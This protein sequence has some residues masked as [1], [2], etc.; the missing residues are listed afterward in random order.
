MFWT[1]F[2]GPQLE[3]E[4]YLWFTCY[5]L[6][7]LI[8]ITTQDLLYTPTLSFSNE[9][10]SS[11]CFSY[12]TCVFYLVI[13][14]NVATLIS[15]TQTLCDL[16]FH[17][18]L[19]QYSRTRKPFRKKRKRWKQSCHASPSSSSQ[20][21]FFFHDERPNPHYY[22]YLHQTHFGDIFQH[23]C[24]IN[25]DLLQ[26]FGVQSAFFSPPTVPWDAVIPLA[27]TSSTSSEPTSYDL[28]SLVSNGNPFRFQS[29]FFSAAGT[30]PLIFDTGASISVSPHCDDFVTYDND[31]NNTTL[32]GVSAST[33]VAGKGIMQLSIPDDT[34]ALRTF[35][36]PALH[37]P[38]ATVRLLS[39]QSFCS[40]YRDK[41]SM[42]INADG[43]TFQF[44]TSLGGNSLIFNLKETGNL[45][46]VLATRHHSDIHSSYSSL[47]VHVSSSPAYTVLDSSNKNLTTAQKLVL[48]LHW[49]LMHINMGW[50]HW[51][52]REGIFPTHIQGATSAFCKCQACQLG[53][54]V[55]RAKGTIKHVLDSKKVGSL[56]RNS[57]TP[58][59][60]VSTDQFVSSVRGRLP[61]TFGKEHSNEKYQGGT[62]FV[63]EA[64]DYVFVQNQVSLNAEETLQGKSR[65]EREALHHGIL[66]K[67]YRGDNGVYRSQK[68]Q[69]D[70][71]DKNQPMRYSG[72]GAHHHNGIAERA[73]R[74]VSTNARTI[75]LHAMIHWPQE[76]QLDLWPFA[77]SYSVYLWNILPRSPSKLSPTEIFYGV[78]SDHSDLKNAKV[79]GCP[80][81]VLD[82]RLQDGKK[83]PKWDPRSQVGQFLGRSTQHASSVGLIRNV[84]TGKVSAQF[85]VVYDN[86]FTTLDVSSVPSSD[87]LPNEW[88]QLFQYQREC[89]FDPKDPTSPPEPPLTIPNQTLPQPALKAPTQQGDSQSPFI[90]TSSTPTQSPTDVPTSKTPLSVPEGAD[91]NI[92]PSQEPIQPSDNSDP[93]EGLRRSSRVKF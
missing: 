90:D 33:V 75:L 54:Q 65:F 64:S 73:I 13:L 39:V 46:K 28:S 30:G 37:V 31:N 58:G 69:Q 20:S 89:Q 86:H 82:P 56:K 21:T 32:Q 80:S 24:T 14:F 11:T 78:K 42:S 79:W 66:I 15:S 87:E 92:V 76:T 50:V 22:R 67:S 59:A 23:Q 71:R 72:V 27:F 3:I 70:L 43:T 57:L 5:Y 35:Q 91:L 17:D 83:I 77:V 38:Q 49:R 81:Y 52:I 8:G 53:K 48:D 88:K 1:L 61:H 85:H 44:P 4:W 55:R 40:T 36:V 93:S 74:T 51:L 25:P 10:L 12:F 45:P 60:I 2:F 26:L 62:I 84:Q 9:T 68:F 18:S 41:A 16:S 19:S 63:D 29:V 7:G 6:L 47:P 34:G